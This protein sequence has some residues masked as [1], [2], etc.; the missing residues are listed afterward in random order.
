MDDPF[1][2][3]VSLHHLVSKNQMRNTKFHCLDFEKRRDSQASSLF[4]LQQQKN[5][6][7]A[8]GFSHYI[9]Q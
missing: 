9:M 8:F 4:E 1:L 2:L 7:F 6:C 5:W 3:F